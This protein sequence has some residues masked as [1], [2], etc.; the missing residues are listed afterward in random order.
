[1]S[2]ARCNNRHGRPLQARGLCTVCYAITRKSGERI[3]YPRSTRSRAELLEDVAVLRE[4]GL[5]RRQMAER[6]AMSRNTLD[7]ALLRAERAGAA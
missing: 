7:Q 5:N 1:M 3:D 4:Q 6:L 2:C